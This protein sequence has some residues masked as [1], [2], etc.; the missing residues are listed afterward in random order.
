M[1]PSKPFSTI[2]ECNRCGA[3][4]LVKK[5]R[6][7]TRCAYCGT[8]CVVQGLKTVEAEAPKDWKPP[9]VWTPPDEVP[10]DSTKPLKY[11]GNRVRNVVIMLSL[12]GALGVLLITIFRERGEKVE[13][14]P[15]Q[16]EKPQ[17]PDASPAPETPR[18]PPKLDPARLAKISLQ[19]TRAELTKKLG[20]EE[21]ASVKLAGSRWAKIRFEWH[22]GPDHVSKVVIAAA[23]A[24]LKSFYMLRKKL[25]LLLP[26]R[27]SYF[28]SLRKERSKIYGSWGWREAKLEFLGQHS[29]EIE[30]NSFPR[31]ED[32][33]IAGIK[34]VWQR[35]VSLLWDIVRVALWDL[36][37]TLDEQ[38]IRR[39]LGRGWP[40]GELSKLGPDVAI[41]QR[42]AVLRRF[43]PGVYRREF[44]AVVLPVDHPW[45][46]S[47][48]FG[49]PSLKGAKP[50]EARFKPVYSNHFPDPLAMALVRCVQKAFGIKGK[51]LRNPESLDPVFDWWFNIPTGGS[52]Q[53]NYSR[54][55]VDFFGHSNHPAPHARMTQAVWLKVLDLIRDCPQTTSKPARQPPPPRQAPARTPSRLPPTRQPPK[56]KS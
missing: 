47:V 28:R 5:G 39:Y 4:L 20:L 7:V 38:G 44:T 31:S 16:V 42:D 1:S 49:W 29:K 35:Q 6:E 50:R 2:L 54:L 52:V 15:S 51:D 23:D 40:V 53:V 22:F 24:P 41:E 30:I 34:D 32:D 37:I 10:A 19:V 3:P 56:V 26:R 25:E 12:L 21:N 43:F 14:K 17:Q 48:D 13:K 36:P 55:D 45:I 33:K 9:P 8:Q 46:E 11:Q 27:W 18:Q